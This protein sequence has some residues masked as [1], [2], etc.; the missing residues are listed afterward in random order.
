MKK[1]F[2]GDSGRQVLVDTL[3]DQKMVAGNADIAEEIARIG[4]L[5]EVKAGTAIITQGGDDSD[6]YSLGGLPR[7]FG[8]AFFRVSRPLVG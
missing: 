7:F 4:E 6:V 1:R 2:A 5:I 8:L 3:K